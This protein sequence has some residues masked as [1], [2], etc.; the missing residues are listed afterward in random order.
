VL[1]WAEAPTHFSS[2]SNSKLDN[3]DYLLPYESGTTQQQL[4]SKTPGGV[5]QAVRGAF[6]PA[7]PP[8]CP[9]TWSGPWGT[10]PGLDKIIG[11]LGS[12]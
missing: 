12:V 3:K 8:W 11:M 5:S 4:A 10:E 9:C 2:G 7:G 6:R 1:T